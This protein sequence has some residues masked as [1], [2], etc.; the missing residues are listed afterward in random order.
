MVKSKKKLVITISIILSAVILLT[1]I[2]QIP[3]IAI[4]NPFSKMDKVI[5]K[6]SEFIDSE[7]NDDI[8]REKD[9]TITDKDDINALEEICFK[10]NITDIMSVFE[11]P[12]C[13]FDTVQII[14]VS[15]GKQIT[16]CP[17][18]DGCNNLMIKA[19]NGRVYYHSL[20]D[21]EMQKL[22]EILKNN[23]QTGNW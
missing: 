17:S 19:E 5:I 2:S 22:I 18:P 1:V 20:S 11:T 12:A 6:C 21:T 15:N 7:T 9:I 3:Y 4:S 13:F 10:Q 8:N 23:G 14:F 16:V